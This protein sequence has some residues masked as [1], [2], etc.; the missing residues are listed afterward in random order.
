MD[1]SNLQTINPF[2]TVIV[3]CFNSGQFLR[4][5]LDSI[6]R[7]SFLSYEIIVVND[8]STDPLTLAV[9]DEFV[10]H[11][12]IIHQKNSGQGSARNLALEIARGKYV[13]FLDSDDF[14][15]PYT[16][17]NYHSVISE[18]SPSVCFGNH[19]PF[20]DEASN[21]LFD[22]P[23]TLIYERFANFFTFYTSTSQN[24][25]LPGAFCIRNNLLGA[26]ARFLD[27]RL[28]SEDLHLILKLAAHHPLV[29][30]S[31]PPVL[32]YRQHESNSTKNLQRSFSGLMAINHNRSLGMYPYF[33]RC[34]II[35][36][37]ILASHSR[38]ASFC[39][40]R[41]FKF[42]QAYLLYLVFFTDNVRLSRVKYLVGF[43]LALFY[44]LFL[45]LLQLFRSFVGLSVR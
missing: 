23:G 11:C 12:T 41:D 45:N 29:M 26:D 40:L 6:L 33:Q 19:Q 16:L 32:A 13:A 1:S 17:E 43:Y 44:F 37:S 36:S 25:F 3:P 7:Q 24:V 28:N 10:S 42:R 2:F 14:W 8:G 5:A 18:F 34:P 35:L 9:L 21:V 39:L 4:F 22:S 31:H 38:S 20:S 30:I 15:Y 27:G